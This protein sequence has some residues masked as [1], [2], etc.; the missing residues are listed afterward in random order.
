MSKVLNFYYKLPNN[1]Y[2]VLNVGVN[3][4][5]AYN[6]LTYN[7]L[8]ALSRKYELLKGYEATDEGIMQYYNDFMK[9]DKEIWSL[10][11]ELDIRGVNTFQFYY[12]NEL[13]VIQTFKLLG[14]QA[15]MHALFDDNTNKIDKIEE[16]YFEACNNGYIQYCCNG[17]YECFGYDFN[18]F[19]PRLLSMKE[20]SL[21]IPMRK[22]YETKLT[23]LD[24]DN[25]Q[26][27]FYKVSIVSSNDNFRKMFAYSKTNTYTSTSLKFALKYREAFDISIALNTDDEYNA[28]LYHDEDIIQS[29]ELFHSW[30]DVLIKGKLKYPKNRLIK[31]LL[32]SVWGSLCKFERLRVKESDL[33]AMNADGSYKYSLDEYDI[34]DCSNMPDNQYYTLKSRVN[35]NYKYNVRL[36]PFLMAMARN[37]IGEI[38]YENHIE[39]SIKVRVV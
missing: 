34:V 9:W 22:G 33:E 28:Y 7:E 14:N 8:I 36:K 29:H 35:S 27:G 38:A 6:T 37:V 20:F 19:F 12:N 4:S 11:K 15:H 2:R 24:Y 3:K 26:F 10:K 16:Q 21:E 17:S 1:N 18:A 30:F 13:A 23:H 31:H 5:L 25:I 32:S 39:S